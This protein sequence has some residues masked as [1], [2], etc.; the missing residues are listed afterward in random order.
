MIAL[1]RRPGVARLGVAGL[2]SEAGDWMLMVALPLFVLQLSGSPLVTAMVFALE[3]VPT[4]LLGPFAGVLVDR[5]E[6]KRLMVGVLVVQ[7]VALL[8]LLAV[9]SPADL[10]IVLAVVVVESVL[11]TVVE[12]ARQAAAARLVPDDELV[13]LGGA[14]GSLSGLARLVG[15]PLGGLA[16]GLGG[17][18]TVVVADAATFAVA[19]AALAAG[20]RHPAPER[21]GP[22]APAGIVRD[23]VDGLAVVRGSAVLR[24]VLLVAAVAAL[25]QGGFVVMF[26]LF[27]VRDLDATDAEVGLLRG[28]Q[29]IGSIAGGVLLGTVA[30]RLAPARLL[31]LALAGFGV[32]T[33]V[34]WN[35]P[36]LT[37]A[38]GWYV[39]LFVAVGAPGVAIGAAM[40]ALLQE[41]AGEAARGRVLSTYGAVIGGVQA[42][43]MLLAGLVG[44]EVGLTVALQVQG[45]L[46]LVAAGLA[47][48]VAR[49]KSLLTMLAAA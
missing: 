45:A 14:F 42:G 6:R 19:A 38:L 13:A 3:L 16:L 26:V 36:L 46:I 48:R 8:P 1:L 10:W 4:V 12:P 49:Q 22:G 15:G 5:W 32:L 39:A 43:G 17:A 33:L 23:W 44:T 21:A 11:G 18:A 47:V 20:P 2:L 9:D 24:R 31:P 7:A 37:T 40:V 28:V 34:I 41:H 27:L 35:L 25:A 30:R 29:A